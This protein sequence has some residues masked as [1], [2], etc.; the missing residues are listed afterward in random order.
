[1]TTDG[2]HADSL[3]RFIALVGV[4]ILCGAVQVASA[5]LGGEAV[6]ED[7]API[8]GEPVYGAPAWDPPVGG[9]PSYG[10]PVEENAPI[11]GEALDPQAEWDPPVGGAP[12]SGEPVEEDAPIGGEPLY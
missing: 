1:V 2:K 11:S 10:E 4:L 6:G 12:L 9:E 5:Q 3:T 8:G 7:D